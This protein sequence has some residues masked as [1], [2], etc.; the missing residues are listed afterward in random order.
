[1]A[2]QRIVTAI[3]VGS[4]KIVTIIADTI[5]G[6]NDIRVLG[7]SS[8]PSKGVKKS[9]IVDLNAA[10]E[11]ITESVDAAERMAG[12]NSQHA[13]VSV[14]GAHIQSQNS[15]G[16]VAVAQPTQEIT[17]EDVDRVIDAAKAVSL[18]TGKEI[19]HVVPKNFKVDAQDGIKDPI[20]MSGIRLESEAHIVTASTV[21]LKNIEKCVNEMGIQVDEFV[22]A[23]LASAEVVVTDTEKELGVLVVD[24]G[25]G[26]TSLCAFVEGSLEYTGVLPIGARHITQD[27]ALGCRV[28]IQ[29]AEKIK[30]ELAHFPESPVVLPGETKE[31]ARKR[32][33]KQ[34]LIDVAKLGISE[35]IEFLSRKAVV[36]G[37]MTPRMQEIFKLI[38][39]ELDKHKLFDVIP[40]GV[41]LT[42]GGAETVEMSEVCKHTLQLATRIGTPTGFK[43]LIDEIEKPKY[44]TALGLL[45]YGSRKGADVTH[46]SGKGGPDFSGLQ[47]IPQKIAQIFKS[48]MP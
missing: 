27:I 10:I 28:S 19:L 11:S 22:F 43:G 36:E 42:G 48:L 40:A 39:Q 47:N 18:P 35:N 7:V 16:V 8:V 1:M 20:G 13:Y 15:K 17:G 26:S 4:E 21:A 25:A 31:D 29:S 14:S 38:G 30:L 23:G 37:I 45:T 46:S 6:P 33:K 9:Q 34:D 3:D 32:R 41:V 24:I 12:I 2:K 44:S 5:Q